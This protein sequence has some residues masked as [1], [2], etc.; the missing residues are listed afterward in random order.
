MD[1]RVGDK[2][3]VKNRTHAG[4][5]ALLVLRVGMD[6]RIRCEECGWK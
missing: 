5:P 2:I 4:Q 3:E 6:F 1:V